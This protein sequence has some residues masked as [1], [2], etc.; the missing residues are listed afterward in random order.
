MVA[1]F[2]SDNSAGVSPEILAALAAA[3]TGRAASYGE[4]DLS[5]ALTEALAELFDC[6]SLAVFPVATGT[7]ANALALSAAVPPW[8]AIYVEASAHVQVD[9]CNAVELL[10]AGAKLQPIVTPDG[11]LTPALLAPA[12]SG[13]GV[14]HHPQPAA[15]SITQSSENGRVYRPEEVAALGALAREHGLALHMDG[16][17]FAN[18]VAA[19]NASPAAVTHAAGVDLLSFGATKNGAMA[20]EAIL[21]FRP[22]LAETLA[23]RRKRAGQ[24]FSKQRY[25]SAQLLAY[26]TDGLWLKNARHANRMA[27]ELITLLERGGGK[28]AYPVEA[29][30]VFVALPDAVAKQ[31]EAA[32]LLFYPWS[33]GVYRFVTSFQTNEADLKAVEKALAV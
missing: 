24:L 31:L 21:V 6:S 33:P 15:I 4:D 8:G 27:S 18:A 25:L 23:F 9:E 14:V 17:R 11:K 20:A 5:K 12:I 7:A 10:T 1:D 26:V 32:Q 22:E 19:L 2:R 13:A 30:E 3:N 16:A 28:A 29:N